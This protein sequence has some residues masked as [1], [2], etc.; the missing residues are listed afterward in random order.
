MARLPRLVIP[1]LPHYVVVRGLAGL[2][3]VV[4]DVDR[5][6]LCDE[7]AA[8]SRA[9]DLALHAFALLPTEL[10]LLTT[11]SSP[12]GLSLFMQAL[13]RRYVP[14]HNR[15]HGRN[16]SLWDRRFRAAVVEPGELALQ[17]LLVVDSLGDPAAAGPGDALHSSRSHH[18]GLQRDP[19]LVDLPD[20]WHL[21][22]TPF[23]RET[24]FAER[25]QA[26]PSPAVARQLQQASSSGWVVGSAS[27]IER[28][29]SERARPLRPRRAGRP[30][31]AT[32]PVHRE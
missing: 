26:G 14:R 8:C 13:G 31:R 30:R 23:E 17:A 1:G 24:R 9:H 21:G 28:L 19:A 12:R 2:P 5:R 15:R 22:N 29:A 7:L 18:L 11:P 3:I 6:A 27:F 25:L 32:A 20:Y 16:G 10:H 4:D